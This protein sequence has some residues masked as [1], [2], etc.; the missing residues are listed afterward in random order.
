MT[1]GEAKDMILEYAVEKMGQ[2]LSATH[3]HEK[4][5][6]NN[7]F[8]EVEF[9]F[10]K[11]TLTVDKVAEI[12]INDYDSFIE[13]NELTKIFLSQGGFT[14]LEKKNLEEFD[15]TWFNLILLFCHFIS[16]YFDEYL[17]MII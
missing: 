5:F 1:E 17:V 8:E 11:M 9:L 4:L 12:T 6:K 2:T 14:E 3:I 16:S 10:E 13:A 7:S 15:Y